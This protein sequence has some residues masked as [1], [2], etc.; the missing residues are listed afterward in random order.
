MVGWV[1]TWTMLGF[2]T[3]SGMMDAGKW[4]M[5]RVG[6][7][8]G[9]EDKRQPALEDMVSLSPLVNGV[10]SWPRN[11]ARIAHRITCSVPAQRGQSLMRGRI[12][13]CVW[14]GRRPSTQSWCSFPR[15]ADRQSMFEVIARWDSW[16]CRR[17]LAGQAF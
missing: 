5:C 16:K 15:G 1:T 3:V 8:V 6:G 10:G 14:G 17:N 13:L 4:W 2:E 11:L 7:R 12:L 9:G